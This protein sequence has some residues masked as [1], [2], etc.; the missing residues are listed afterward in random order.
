[1]TAGV[2]LALGADICVKILRERGFLPTRGFSVVNLYQI[3]EGLN[4]ARSSC[5]CGNMA[6][7]CALS[8]RENRELPIIRLNSPSVVHRNDPPVEHRLL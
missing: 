8:A 6:R 3:A 7:S 4:A 2:T 1:M 5:I